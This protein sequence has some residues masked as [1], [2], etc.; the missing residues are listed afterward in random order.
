MRVDRADDEAAAGPAAPDPAGFDDPAVVGPDPAAHIDLAAGLDLLGRLGHHHSHLDLVPHRTGVG[1]AALV[2]RSLGLG[3]VPDRTGWPAVPAGHNLVLGVRRNRP[4]A[5]VHRI[6][7]FYFGA[8][9][10]ELSDELMNFLRSIFDEKVFEVVVVEGELGN[11]WWICIE[12]E[13][14]LRYGTWKVIRIGVS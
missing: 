13:K 1:L 11:P 7:T 6:E 8:G 4:V 10:E 12:C 14:S 5:V 2:V 3:P 9:T